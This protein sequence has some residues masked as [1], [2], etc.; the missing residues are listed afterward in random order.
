MRSVQNSIAGST[1][2]YL[3]HCTFTGN[4]SALNAATTGNVDLDGMVFTGNEEGL[5]CNSGTFSL[6]GSLFSDNER[7]MSIGGADAVLSGSFFAG[8]T[9]A[10][11]IGSGT[12]VCEGLIFSANTKGIVTF[13]TTTL[14]DCLFG[15]NSIAVHV[16][17]GEDGDGFLKGHYNFFTNSTS[18][19]IEYGSAVH[20]GVDDDFVYNWFVDN[21]S[22][23]I[24]RS[25]SGRVYARYSRFNDSLDKTE[26]GIDSAD[27]LL[28]AQNDI[29]PLAASGA[30]TGNHRWEGQYA[31]PLHPTV[32]LDYALQESGEIVIPGPQLI[33]FHSR[34]HPAVFT[35]SATLRIEG[36]STAEVLITSGRDATTGIGNVPPQVLPLETA[37]PGNNDFTGLVLNNWGPDDLCRWARLRYGFVEFRGD[38]TSTRNFYYNRLERESPHDLKVVL[39]ITSTHTADLKYNYWG[40]NN[41]VFADV[42][43][44]NSGAHENIPW[45]YAD[46][47][48]ESETWPV[49]NTGGVIISTIEVEAGRII[50]IDA[51]VEHVIKFAEDFSIFNTT[52]MNINGLGKVVIT[53]KYDDMVE[54]APRE[55]GAVTMGWWGSDGFN[56]APFAGIGL[57][58][59]ESGEEL[60]LRN[61]CL[62]A[63]SFGGSVSGSLTFTDCFLNLDRDLTSDSGFLVMNQS[64]CKAASSAQLYKND[65]FVT[66]TDSF[67][68][69]YRDNVYDS[70]EICGLDPMGDRFSVTSG[71]PVMRDWDGLFSDGSALSLGRCVFR[72]ANTACEGRDFTNLSLFDGN[73]FFENTKGFVLSDSDVSA[74]IVKLTCDR[75]DYGI[76]LDSAKNITVG[77][78]NAGN[79]NRLW[80]GIVGLEAGASHFLTIQRNLFGTDVFPE[81]EGADLGQSRHA[82]NIFGTD[83]LTIYRN[84]IAFADSS[85][86]CGVNLSGSPC[87]VVRIRENDF[88]RNDTGIMVSGSENLEIGQVI[89]YSDSERESNEFIENRIGIDLRTGSDLH[90]LYN[91]FRDQTEAGLKNAVSPLVY[92]NNFLRGDNG[93]VST[94]S[95]TRIFENSFYDQSGTALNVSSVFESPYLSRT[96]RANNIYGS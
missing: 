3:R 6:S 80:R 77:D 40:E 54:A 70:I 57:F 33:E 4:D 69:S 95:E 27:D 47:V 34:S 19:A 71:T 75:N 53:T 8:N 59:L 13:S 2:G 12:A 44:S 39:N 17:E 7:G 65:S 84:K 67:F 29:V 86:G 90:V 46:K 25:G 92:G 42:I 61:G 41:P 22:N 38:F 56:V 78:G 26:A 50:T 83:N 35:S 76:Y 82:I 28:Q 36:T 93:I 24:R 37:G 16:P 30:I 60:E 52:G 18:T 10:L 81:D 49:V 74:S 96:L 58:S 5:Q 1:S 89:S 66:L 94:G 21:N 87:R 48:R 43:F 63:S 73:W 64:L 55:G 51:P 31:S 62:N 88:F 85:D 72:Y 32:I 68:T 9:E 11:R 14:H 15:A 91:E 45:A 23:I 20:T 79:A